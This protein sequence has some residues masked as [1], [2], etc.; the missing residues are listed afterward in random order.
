MSGKQCSSCGGK[1]GLAA[2]RR[3]CDRRVC[4]RRND[5]FQ[6]KQSESKWIT[7]LRKELMHSK[8]THNFT[9]SRDEVNE[10]LNAA[11]LKE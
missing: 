11:P 5:V 3:V 4:D 6:E 2:D 1:S 8:M 7:D 9:F 10:L